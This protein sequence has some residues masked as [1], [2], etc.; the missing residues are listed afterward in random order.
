MER[1]T[2][3][4]SPAE[5]LAFRF[6]FTLACLYIAFVLLP[7]LLWTTP[8]P[9]AIGQFWF[10]RVIAGFWWPVARWVKQEVLE[11][12]AA[13]YVDAEPTAPMHV[14]VGIGC[15]VLLA[16]AVTSVWSYVDRKR[17]DY[18]ALNEW[19]RVGLRYSVGA[20]LLSYGFSKVFLQQFGAQPR[21]SDLVTPVGLLNQF[22][23]LA[24]FMATSPAYQ[25]F[26]GWVEVV[27]GALLMVRRTSRIGALL[28][29]PVMAN[30]V[31]LNFAYHFT[32]YVVS[33]GML[34]MAVILAVPELRRLTTLLLLERQVAAPPR[35][36]LFV[37]PSLER[38]TRVLGVFVILAV[39]GNV[40][41]GY[42]DQARRSRTVPALHGVYE[43]EQIERNG[44]VIPPL[45]TDH[46]LWRRVIV[47]GG[48]GAVLFARDT[49]RF[50]VRADT[51][52]ARL[53][54]VFRRDPKQPSEWSYTIPDADRVILAGVDDLRRRG[55]QTQKPQQPESDTGA[56]VRRVDS[57]RVTMRR[58]DI[59][60]LPLLRSQPWFR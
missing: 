52:R 22:S 1:Q 6:L 48:S 44:V 46:S 60:T 31:V 49:V 23:M 36:P 38:I 14:L 55:L 19:F 35:L 5:R 2:Q 13:P 17:P 8:L 33:T 58:M 16:A 37:N 20:L 53:S 18:R 12:P 29:V 26:T 21:L 43:V 28:A 50:S 57:V 32:M 25:M 40:A 7:Q 39:A 41:D 42:A 3:P 30:V 4:W 47:D 34:V 54:L 59:A 11:I 56:S 24:T 45:L 15:M 51:T 10:D 9:D 27:T